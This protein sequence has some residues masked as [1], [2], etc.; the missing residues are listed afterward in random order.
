MK[1]IFSSKASE[2]N[3]SGDRHAKEHPQKK[4]FRGCFGYNG[5]GPIDSMM[6]SEQYITILNKKVVP[7]LKKQY[8]DGTGIFQQDLVPCHASK[9]VKKCMSENK[10]ETVEW[11]GNSPNINTIVNL[12]AI[13]KNLIY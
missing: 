2:H 11:P 12:W 9:I 6:H 1:T 13:C 7:E 10:I 8:P 5:V 3:M 4:M